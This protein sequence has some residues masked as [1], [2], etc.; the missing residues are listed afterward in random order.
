MRD[1]TNLGDTIAGEISQSQ[2]DKYHMIV[3]AGGME[4][5]QTHGGQCGCQ[6]PFSG[7]EVPVL[8]GG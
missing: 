7:H 2:E 4:G 1:W 8:Q 5:S 3:P 6:E